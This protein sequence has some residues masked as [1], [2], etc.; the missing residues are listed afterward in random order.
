MLA[1]AVFSLSIY[2]CLRDIALHRISNYSNFALLIL[3]S[4]DLDLAPPRL[5]LVALLFAISISAICRFGGGD[6]KLLAL[7][8]ATQGAVVI[9]REYLEL[10]LLAASI[11]LT[12]AVV[13]RRSLAGSIPMAP[14]ILTPF[15]ILYLAI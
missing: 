14:A 4:L 2:I 11:S 7:L 8:I 5:V 9:S 12:L 6:F 15:L 1:L 3:L 10:F 13:V